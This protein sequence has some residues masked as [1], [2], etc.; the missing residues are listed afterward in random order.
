MSIF[1]FSFLSMIF[2]LDKIES[3]VTYQ[4]GEER[5]KKIPS[6]P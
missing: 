4:K 5:E 6:P 2:R 1:N 3:Y